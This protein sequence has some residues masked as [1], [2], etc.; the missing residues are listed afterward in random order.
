M[1]FDFVCAVCFDQPFVFAVRVICVVWPYLF[2]LLAFCT[3]VLCA[4]VNVVCLHSLVYAVCAVCE[5]LCQFLL[6]LLFV[7]STAGC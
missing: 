7:S 3:C 6:L 4:C 5:P 1:W 2:R